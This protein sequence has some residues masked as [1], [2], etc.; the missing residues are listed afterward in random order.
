MTPDQLVGEWSVQPSF[1]IEMEESS[2]EIGADDPE[3]YGT[4]VMRFRSDGSGTVSAD[5]E[6]R[7]FEWRLSTEGD[8]SVLSLAYPG[9]ESESLLM[10][11]GEESVIML[12]NQSDS[13][14][15]A[16]LRRGAE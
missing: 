9:Y 16:I 4:M 7:D 12:E 11:V 5:E 14:Y 2:L 10:P 15:V 8:A 13:A 1:V 6:A 3:F